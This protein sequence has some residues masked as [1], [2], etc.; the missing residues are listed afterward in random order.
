MNITIKICITVDRRWL[1]IL[2]HWM[3]QSLWTIFCPLLEGLSYFNIPLQI[4]CHKCS[5][6]SFMNLPRHYDH[7]LNVTSL[8][9]T[10]PDT[11]WYSCMGTRDD[12]HRCNL[13]DTTGWGAKL[14]MGI[15]NFN[16]Q[17]SQV[18]RVKIALNQSL[19]YINSFPF[20]S[21]LYLPLFNSVTKRKLCLS[22]KKYWEGERIGT[23]LRKIMSCIH[24]SFITS[25][26]HVHYVVWKWKNGWSFFNTTCGITDLL[27]WEINLCQKQPYLKL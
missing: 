14:T 15:R 4:H 16:L 26:H 13:G 21:T 7:M 20:P 6:T 17:S 25:T 5:V 1:V 24:S 22:R 11:F 27:Q 12:W 8:C 10:C 2:P 3:K 9:F 23:I 19:I 18:R